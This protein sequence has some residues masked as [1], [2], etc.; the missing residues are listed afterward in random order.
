MSM[1]K[2]SINRICGIF[3]ML[4][5]LA[6]GTASVMVYLFTENKNAVWCV[7]LFSFLC[8]SVLYALWL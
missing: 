6:A 3:G 4:L 7:V 1:K 2:F 8:F 5:M